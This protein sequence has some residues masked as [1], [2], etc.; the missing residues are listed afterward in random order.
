MQTIRETV[1]SFKQYGSISED[2]ISCVGLF[3]N[4]WAIFRSEYLLS[5]ITDSVRCMFF[6]FSKNSDARNKSRSIR[7]SESDRD[8]RRVLSKRLQRC[9]RVITYVKRAIERKRESL[10]FHQERKR[11]TKAVSSDIVIVDY[12]HYTYAQVYHHPIVTHNFY[13]AF[14]KIPH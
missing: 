1:L 13:D 2:L 3:K 6:F 10:F 8:E 12:T 7:M 5:E 11:N 4:I 14:V 9:R